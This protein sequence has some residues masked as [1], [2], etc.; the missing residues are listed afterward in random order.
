MNICAKILNKILINQI[1]EHIKI[2]IHHDQIG[3]IP[4]MQGWF[5]IWKAINVIQ[6]INK[7][8][9]NKTHDHLIK[10]WKNHLT[11]FNIPSY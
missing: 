4:G 8:K 3:F 5:N 7:V 6:Y 9:E 11:K 2:I 1:Q 10:M